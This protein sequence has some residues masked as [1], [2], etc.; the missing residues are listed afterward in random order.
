MLEKINIRNYKSIDDIELNL[1]RINVLIGENGAGKS[2]ILEA[3]ALAGAAE[4]NKL[5]NEF[6]AT[7][8]IRVTSP[9]LMKA[10]FAKRNIRPIIVSIRTKDGLEIVYKMNNDNKPYSKW[11]SRKEIK[12][13][14]SKSA[15]NELTKYFLDM[16]APLPK[17]EKDKFLGDLMKVV[18]NQ[19]PIED[20]NK[21]DNG[22]VLPQPDLEKP[23]SI[24]VSSETPSLTFSSNLID[25]FVI[26]SP[27]NSALRH[28]EKEG[29]LQPLGING[30][31][32]LKLLAVMSR[33]KN[34][35][36]LHQVKSALQR[37]SW[38][39]DFV[40]V[41]RDD[42]S[43]IEITDCFLGSLSRGFDQASANEGFL[44]LA[45]YFSLFSSQLTPQF[46]A[47][48]NIDVS[49]NPKLCHAMMV[50]L[51]EASKANEKQA[52]LTTHNPAVLDGLDLHDDEQRLFIVS[53]DRRGKTQ[54]RRFEKKI[55][56]GFPSRMSELFL[57]GMIGGLPKS[58]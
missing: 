45:F 28:F 35:I 29:Q 37:L 18:A 32:L 51:V 1:G 23:I 52:I 34:S 55:P 27:E 25:Q 15:L 8:G 16:L 44:F 11:N 58:F 48:D 7:R 43:V 20:S 46:F 2:N 53:R 54:V 14:G 22:N 26:Y 21:S 12:M 41:D 36:A 9:F 13:G 24:N 3:I 57:R 39:K 33:D 56:Q 40:I 31:G 19:I 10:A 30:E 5:D 4:A 38:F 47:I 50:D 49:L 17:D 42:H 6:L